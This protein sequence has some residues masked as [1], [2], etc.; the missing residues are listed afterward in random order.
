M[1]VEESQ[2][3]MAL[4]WSARAW[5][6][7]KKW[8]RTGN[9]MMSASADAPGYALFYSV[10][11]LDQRLPLFLFWRFGILHVACKSVLRWSFDDGQRELI[12]PVCDV[13]LLD[14]G[15]LVV[16][17]HDLWHCHDTA[18]AVVND[19]PPLATSKAYERG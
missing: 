10:T 4:T 14:G 3:L 18:I 9:S 5:R 16:V 8:A 2:L 13:R 6:H 12:V 1:K 19:M 17:K 11:L 15:Q 7:L